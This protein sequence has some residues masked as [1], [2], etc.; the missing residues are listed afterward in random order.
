MPKF[1]HECGAASNGGKFCSEC[2]TRFT[3]AAPAGL[4]PVPPAAAAAA[5]ASSWQ[6]NGVAAS[7]GHANGNGNGSA[8]PKANEF[9]QR[10]GS[11]QVQRS[12]SNGGSFKSPNPH[13]GS[14]AHQQQPPP[15]P[16]APWMQRQSSGSAPGVPVAVPVGAAGAGSPTVYKSPFPGTPPPPAVPAPVEFVPPA[17]SGIEAQE[18]YERCVHTI[19]AARGGNNEEGVKAFKQNCRLYGL[20]QMDVKSFYDS[21]VRELGQ[22]G[23]LDFVPELARLVPDDD[24]RRELIEFNTSKR[25]VPLASA[26]GAATPSPRY[27]GYTGYASR[28]SRSSSSS[29]LG[30]RQSFS[31]NG[32]KGVLKNRYGD[33]PN[34]DICN[35]R[36]DVTKRRHQ[37]RHCGLYVCSS[38]SPLR[39]L[40]PPGR[41][42]ENAKGYDPAIPQRVCIQCAP[43]LHSVQD[44][45]V[46]Q[47]A[48]ANE[49]NIH[50]A[51]GRLHVPYSNSLFKE[52]QNAADIIGNF[53]RDDWGAAADRSIPVSFLQKAH[54]LAIMTIV[55]AGFLVTGQ[56][57]TGLVV[58]KLPD[59]SWSAP[60]AIGTI[61]L[62]GGF[63]IGG[64]IVEV[65]IILGSEGAV[66][67][68]HKP[69]VNLGAGLD[70]A[71][72]PYGRSAVAAAAASASGLNANY[73][74]SHSKGLYAGISLQGTIIAARSDLN[75]KFYGRDLQPSEIL[76]GHI[77]APNAARPLYEAIAHAMQGIEMHKET[78]ARRASIIGPCRLCNCPMFV[79]HTHQIWNKNC[80]TCKHIL[81]SQL[82][83]Y[84]DGLSGDSLQV[85]L[86]SGELALHDLSLKPHA[87]AELRLPVTVVK[88]SIRRIHVIVPWNQ[89][90]S[91]SVQIT[92]EGVYALV[93]PNTTLPSTEEMHQFKRNQ[94]ERLELLRQ[95][96]RLAATRN[97][98]GEDEG[99]FLS[100][101]TER[102]VDNLQITLRDL[103]IRYED[104]VSNAENPFACG[105]MVQSFTF[106]TTDAEGNETF[107][108][109]S[110]RRERFL[111]KAIKVAY[112]VL[113]AL[114][115]IPVLQVLL[116][117][118]L[119]Q[120]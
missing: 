14:P 55:K 22:D 104:N 16:A 2:G 102:I 117:L 11:P 47:F 95:H 84:V 100:R 99:T 31:G 92:I 67:V 26:P 63:E 51:R 59:G 83:K 113:L 38:C 109:R 13:M 41:E 10:Y 80:K 20:K 86:W 54:G 58:A 89:L 24:R 101:L 76:S 15:P 78:I 114:K 7:N 115:E 81:E 96:D 108:D 9:M 106:Q 111:H 94:I 42:I 50:E 19:R 98:D 68:F 45:L 112:A 87:L 120:E 17:A 82:G 61:G 62:G 48:K 18:C 5:V 46:A 74:Y 93:T 30:D 23:T 25:P 52:C 43:Q 64:E 4:P 103:H 85:G 32:Q 49:D 34:C 71:V 110:T 107:V 105:V 116:R 97:R 75:R 1:C 73:S 57:G 29:S 88:G 37:C 21:L 3:D 90:G 72:G 53:F 27:G 79:A 6:T 44:E 65:M 8:A 36:F 56:L 69:Q 35:I 66:K 40:I 12:F 70:I 119:F 91:A 60:A 28:E 39:L 77:E 118:Q 33:H